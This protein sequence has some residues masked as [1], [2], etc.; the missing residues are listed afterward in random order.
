MILDAG[1]YGSCFIFGAGSG[2]ETGC[3]LDAGS[4]V[5]SMVFDLTSQAELKLTSLVA[6]DVFELYVNS[7]LTLITNTPTASGFAS[8]D[9]D[10][11]FASTDFSSESIVLGPGSY[12]IDI[13]LAILSPDNPFAGV[14]VSAIELQSVP[15]PAAIWLFGSG[16]LGLIG[17]ARRKKTA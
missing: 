4:A 14:S 2:A 16:L 5:N 8:T 9:A 7:V 1:W 11:A 13:Y 6:G 15:V 10:A 17:I 3:G 12:S